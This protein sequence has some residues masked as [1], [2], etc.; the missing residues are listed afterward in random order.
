MTHNIE[1]LAQDIDNA[2]A[3]SVEVD[4]SLD[5]AIDKALATMRHAADALAAGANALHTARNAH[6]QQANR[7][8]DDH[9]DTAAIIR[10]HSTEKD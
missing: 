3:H 4:G 10:A 7:I 1:Q 9:T 8:R 5:V 6:N 2:V